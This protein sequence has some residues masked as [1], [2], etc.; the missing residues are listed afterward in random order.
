MTQPKEEETAFLRQGGLT[1]GHFYVYV[2]TRRPDCTQLE[3]RNRYNDLVLY[4]AYSFL[5]FRLNETE[6]VQ[7]FGSANHVTIARWTATGRYE[8]TNTAVYCKPNAAAVG[9]V[10]RFNGLITFPT[11]TPPLCSIFN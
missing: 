2:V 5:N 4:G 1:G 11:L 7:F 3:F 6:L 9:T 8:L 10:S